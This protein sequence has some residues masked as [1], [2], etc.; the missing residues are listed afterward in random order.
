MP[1]QINIYLDTNVLIPIIIPEDPFRYTLD[2]VEL[3]RDLGCNLIVVDRTLQELRHLVRVQF[4]FELRVLGPRIK[5]YGVRAGFSSL[6]V[7][8]YLQ[9]ERRTIFQDVMLRALDRAL[10][11]FH[12]QKTPSKQVDQRTMEEERHLF[13]AHGRYE[14]RAVEHDIILSETVKQAADQGKG[15]NLIVTNDMVLSRIKGHLGCGPMALTYI[16]LDPLYRVKTA[17]KTLIRRIES[18][19]LDGMERALTIRQ[20]IY[21][22]LAVSILRNAIPPGDD[23]CNKPKCTACRNGFV[24]GENFP[25]CIGEGAPDLPRT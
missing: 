2:V 4:P 16:V 19:A 24:R 10:D 5:K 13:A 18:Q 7:H 25:S 8:Y 14:A 15:L 21:T 11:T 3:A 20:Y 9:S 17:G 6:F 22:T 23:S 1:K 12:I